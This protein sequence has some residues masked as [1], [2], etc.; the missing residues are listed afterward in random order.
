MS[1]TSVFASFTSYRSSH[2]SQ[3]QHVSQEARSEHSK[4][5]HQANSDSVDIAHGGSS[6]RASELTYSAGPTATAAL[7]ELEGAES[8]TQAAN[9]ILDFVSGRL[10]LD[11]AEGATEE[12]LVSR[13]EAGLS[14]FVKGYQE[15]YEQLAGMGFLTA[16]VEEAI[17]KTFTDVMDGI[18]ALAEE[19]GVES[20]V[21]QGLRDE[22]AERRATFVPAEPAVVVA[23]V[24]V[25]EAVQPGVPANVEAS[26]LRELISASSFDYRASEARSFNF[27]LKTQ[28]GDTVNI[29]A[30][31]ASVTML[32]GESVRYNSDAG[33]SGTDTAVTGQFRAASGF[34]LDV[35]G[36][37][38]EDEMMAIEDLLTQVREVS[39]MFF[40][41]DIESAFEY[42]TEVGFNTDE[43]AEFSLR[44]RSSSSVRVEEA[45]QQPQVVQEQVAHTKAEALNAKDE[46]LMLIARFVQALEDLR[47]G[48]KEL[49][50]EDF[51][52][53]LPPLDESKERGPEGI[54][55]DMLTRLEALSEA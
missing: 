3:S 32:D 24:E 17:E 10:R 31:Y 34:Y 35:R 44:L 37:I 5:R 21:T 48:A 7:P 23:P 40:A 25:A 33:R 29:R 45:Y 39:D 36:E 12:D 19:L 53:N 42:A 49:G 4:E 1:L 13:L 50:L 54:V 8:R 16:E 18:D 52:H 55:Q 22:Q 2:S 30:A 9:T 43:I 6:G 51:A 15:A 20:P 28:D 26:N 14:G 27:S 41:G 11:V 47:A 46:K 38:D